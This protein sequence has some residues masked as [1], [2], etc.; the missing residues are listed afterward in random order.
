M[1]ILKQ[2]KEE[3]PELVK[4]KSDNTT[5]VKPLNLPVKCIGYEGEFLLGIRLDT[6]EE[7]KIKLVKIEQKENSKYKRVEIVEFSN[8]KHKYHAVPGQAVFIAESC[9]L[10]S[11]NIYSSRW[12][13]VISPDP[14]IGKV[15]IYQ[16][17][18]ISFK[19]KISE[20]VTNETIMVKIAFPE[21]AKIVNSNE[22][23]EKI[24]SVL[25]NPKSVGSNPF[26]YVR[27]KDNNS[28]DVE[29]VEV[30]PQRTD[31]ED[32]LGKKCVDGVI[33]AKN[34]MESNDS[35][36]I[37]DLLDS[38]SGEISVDVIPCAIIYPGPATKEKMIDIH[39]NA[40]KIFE[41]AFY[42]K[43]ELEEG[44]YPEVGY[45]KCTLVTRKHAD[46]TSYFTFV[47]PIH[48]FVESTRAKD[49]V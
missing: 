43:S 48:Q 11:D 17:S 25:L 45:L 2:Y 38:A 7:I 32:G 14:L 36:M 44:A 1:S 30:T 4:A 23:L 13:K 49:L 29:S 19:R 18:L 40:K 3:H 16:C 31:R 20:D 41:E 12:L 27:I 8:P 22:E 15:D 10:L 21:K 24:L 9:Y 39:P 37:R 5:K 33:S 35:K 46:G 47:K 34:F 26:C 42:I 28:D 6:N